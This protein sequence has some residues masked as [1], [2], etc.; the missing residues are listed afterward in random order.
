MTGPLPDAAGA[1]LDPFREHGGRVAAARAAFGGA[2]ADWIDLSTG[3]APWPYPAPPARDDRLPE[4]A[5][6]AAL[7]AAARAAFGVAADREVVAAPGSDLALRL[8]GVAL[9]PSRPA[10]VRPGYGGHLAAFP[11]ATPIAAGA[12]ATAAGAHDLLVVASPAN[13]DGRALDPALAA[14]LAAHTRLLVDEAYADP[15]PALMAGGAADG[16]LVVLRSFG[17]FYGL[18]GL[19]LGF[20]IAAPA[21]AARVRALLG[22]WPVSAAVIAAGVAA[23]RDEAWRGAQ[24]TRIADAGERLDAVLARAGLDV[25]GSAPL[26]RLVTCPGASGADTLFRRLARRAILTR[27]FADAPD[28]LRIGL[29][30]NVAATD[31]LAAALADRP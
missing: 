29:P 23:Y 3:I 31:R 12:L 27:P 20:V 30:A 7:E 14:E 25:V 5:E 28:R 13:P 18:P 24:E 22:D 2:A 4:P 6:I 8:L 10:V 11:G 21:L 15:A 26:F 19:R 1:R 16:A 17:K 9:S